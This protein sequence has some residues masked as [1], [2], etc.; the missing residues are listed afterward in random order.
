[1]FKSFFINACISFYP[2]PETSSRERNLAVFNSGKNPLL[3]GEDLA[4]M[5]N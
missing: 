2:Q 4:E 5:K 3:T 1:M